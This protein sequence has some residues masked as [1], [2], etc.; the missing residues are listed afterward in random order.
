MKAPPNSPQLNLCEY[1]NRTLRITANSLRTLPEYEN[2][3]IGN[4][5]HDQKLIKQLE[6]LKNIIAAGLKAMK[7]QPSQSG[8]VL[9]MIEVFHKVAA[10]DGYLDYTE[11]M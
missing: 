8:S 2:R 1:Y 11:P 3:L 10:K 7:L 4:Y 6:A 5:E 9:K